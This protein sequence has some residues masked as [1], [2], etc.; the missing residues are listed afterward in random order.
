MLGFFFSSLDKVKCNKYLELK[1]KEWR[2]KKKGTSSSLFGT[3]N[4]NRAKRAVPVKVVVQ[5]FFGNRGSHLLHSIDEI[6]IAYATNLFIYLFIFLNKILLF[7]FCWL[8]KR[9]NKYLVGCDGRYGNV[10]DA[11]DRS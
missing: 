2:E 8:I 11:S 3:Q 6:L 5:V 4:G 9:V 10:F 7:I 1:K